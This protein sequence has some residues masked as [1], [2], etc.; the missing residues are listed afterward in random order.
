MAIYQFGR[1]QNHSS[2]WELEED[3]VNSILVFSASI[4]ITFLIILTRVSLKL[5][6]SKK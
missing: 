2:W 6:K 3:E 1:R 4:L 5:R